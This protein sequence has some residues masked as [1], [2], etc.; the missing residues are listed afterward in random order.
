MLGECGDWSPLLD[1]GNDDAPF[2]LM[3]RQVAAL[4]GNRT[5]K[6]G[7]KSDIFGHFRTFSA[8][9]SDSARKMAKH[10]LPPLDAGAHGGLHEHKYITRTAIGQV[11]RLGPG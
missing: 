7:R 8:T 6:N 5:G 1:F 4:H 3:R 9:S 11:G 10:S 2:H